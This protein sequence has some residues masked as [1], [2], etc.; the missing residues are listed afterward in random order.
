VA[1]VTGLV[2]LVINARRVAA[3][4]HVQQIGDMPASSSGL[5]LAAAKQ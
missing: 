3:G 4:E 5:Q 1:A 2:D